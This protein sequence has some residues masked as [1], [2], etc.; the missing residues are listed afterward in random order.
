[1][2]APGAIATDFGGG[3]MRDDPQVNRQLATG[4]A[5]GRVGLPDDVGA[6]VA[7]PLSEAMGWMN[8]A[9]VEVSG[10]QSVV[11]TTTRAAL[12]RCGLSAQV[13]FCDN[14]CRHANWRAA[15]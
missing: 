3:T 7:A 13:P 12:C 9:R 4:I 5:L 1:V 6:A 10:G 8:G 11:R 15:P 2:I 14:A